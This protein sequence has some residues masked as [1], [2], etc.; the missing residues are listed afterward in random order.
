MR[1]AQ[2]IAIW[3]FVRLGLDVAL[4][5]DLL[6]ECER[7]RSAIWY[8]RQ[9][10]IAVWIG[11]WG[12]IRDHK[13][14]SWRAVATGFAMEYFLLFLYWR[15]SPMLPQRHMLSIEAW[16]TNSSIILLTQAATG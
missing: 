13:A 3:L 11:I 9:V 15:V 4:T 10:L 14:L 2:A 7:G 1:S 16:I 6:E 5:G 12:A 8:W